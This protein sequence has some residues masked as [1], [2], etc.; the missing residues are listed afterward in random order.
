M[1]RITR[2]KAAE[3]AEK[4]HIDEDALLELPG[5]A[6]DPALRTPSTPEQRQALGELE[7]NSA[8][9]GHTDIALPTD[10]KQS[11]RTK[12]KGGRF[13]T[14]AN[15]D[16]EAFSTSA[17]TESSLAPTPEVM[18]DEVEVA[19]SPASRAASDDLV[20]DLPEFEMS[21][22]P[23]HDNRPQSP[24][25]KAVNLIRSQLRDIPPEEEIAD[26]EAITTHSSEPV[27]RQDL[28]TASGYGGES[29]ESMPNHLQYLTSNQGDHA[30]TGEPPGMPASDALGM[31]QSTYDILEAAAVEAQTPPKGGRLSFTNDDAITEM[32]ALDE[33][34][35]QLSAEV[36]DVQQS[37]QK[38]K[39]RKSSAPVVRMSKAAQARISSAQ[40]KDIAITPGL[41]KS[42]ISMAG[43]GQPRRIASASSESAL[44]E[45]TEKKDVFIPHSKP[46]P[47]SLQFPT[48]PPPPKS[49]KAPTQS[50]FRLPGEE[51]AARLKAAKEARLARDAEEQT[52][53][54]FRAR[55]APPM[56]KAPAVRQ[57]S[58]SK[59]RESIAVGEEL[60]PKTFKARPAP[61]LTKAPEVRQ[62]SASKARMSLMSGKPASTINAGVHKRANS[63]A[64]GRALLGGR[65]SIVKTPAVPA[66]SVSVSKRPATAMATLN[67]SRSG[68]API[69]PAA[70]P[71]AAVTT[72][73]RPNYLGSSTR[74]NVLSAASK[75]KEVF[76]RA[77]NAKVSAEQQ[78][79][80]KEEAAKKA[81]ADAAERSRQLSREWA[82]KQKLRKMGVKADLKTKENVAPAA[83]TS[84]D[85][86]AAVSDEAAVEA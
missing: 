86:E 16:N 9:S 41:G 26:A 21:H 46:R 5:D 23:V 84:L 67:K 22:L 43:L 74:T 4:M 80:E 83:S 32:D 64:T 38:S 59:A 71:K 36:P 60:K 10:L 14:E 13:G 85:A 3:V 1:G 50:T 20:K 75:G 68:I 39:P 29:A 6:I 49:T 28:H 52:K 12:K 77:A 42:R 19:G 69:A 40:G 55:A 37:P 35:E 73:E 24:P 47:M 81:R 33:A 54:V 56:T 51:V 25:S 57:T 65:L 79:R 66:N 7:Q 44:D 70:K 78:K 48:P 82:E 58:T 76:N 45:A 11:I 53:K 27:S 31:D 34:V 72:S 61:T 63:V 17:S 15:N 8:G 18:A 2:A 30:K 62:T